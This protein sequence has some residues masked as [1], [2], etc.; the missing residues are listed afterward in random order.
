[1]EAIPGGYRK[2]LIQ[3]NSCEEKDS[4]PSEAGGKECK[5]EGGTLGNSGRL[6]GSWRS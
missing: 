4:S 2:G 5:M 1:M 6:E 3:Q